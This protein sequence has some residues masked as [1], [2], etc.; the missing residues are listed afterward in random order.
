[1]SSLLLSAPKAG[2]KAGAE[3]GA[4]ADADAEGPSVPELPA[5]AAPVPERKA[6]EYIPAPG[7]VTGAVEQAVAESEAAAEKSQEEAVAAAGGTAGAGGATGS[8]DATGG[9][10][11]TSGETGAAAAT[12]AE[13]ATGSSYHG[14]NSPLAPARVGDVKDI[15]KAQAREKEAGHWK[16]VLDSHGGDSKK[17]SKQVLQQFGLHADQEK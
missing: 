10:S 6:P 15:L 1:M 17:Y 13:G 11:E 3:A 12:A 2:A 16:W 7:D 4:N 9:G 5:D 14:I 8:G